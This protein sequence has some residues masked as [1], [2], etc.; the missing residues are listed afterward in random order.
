MEQKTVC[1]RNSEHTHSQWN[2]CQK[3]AFFYGITQINSPQ[4]PLLIIPHGCFWIHHHP[5]VES[6]GVQI[7]KYCTEVGLWG[8]F[9]LFLIWFAATLTV[10][11]NTSITALL[12]YRCQWD[13]SNSWKGELK[14][15][16]LSKSINK[17]TEVKTQILTYFK[18]KV[19]IYFFD[20][21]YSTCFC[22]KLMCDIF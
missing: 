16:H 3:M 14:I 10:L 1:E 15:F 18:V 12:R 6:N 13:V 19:R 9:F 20:W 21:K 11:L 7:F 22:N 5:G 8:T 4:P 17:Y 2:K